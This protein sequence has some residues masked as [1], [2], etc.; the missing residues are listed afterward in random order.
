MT[1]MSGTNTKH[2]YVML[3][4]IFVTFVTGVTS[5]L[6]WILS[7][8]TPSFL[9]HYFATMRFHT[10][11]CVILTSLS[12]VLISREQTIVY[13]RILST[14]FSIAVISIALVRIIEY[15]LGLELSI[16]ANPFLQSTAAEIIASE[17]MAVGTCLIFILLNTSILLL[18]HPEKKEL[19]EGLILLSLGMILLAVF[20]YIFQSDEH[21][22]VTLNFKLAQR[23]I[24]CLALLAFAILLLRPQQGIAKILF[25]DTKHGKSL[26]TILLIVT[27][28]PLILSIIFKIGLAL[29]LYESDFGYGLLLTSCFTI[30]FFLVW[31]NA[32]KLNLEEEKAADYYKKM[33]LSEKLFNEF[34]ENIHDVLWRASA[35]EN[36]ITYISPAF[37][38]IWGRSR[39]SIYENPDIWL[40]SVIPEDRKKVEQFFI[41]LAKDRPTVSVE[42]RIIQPD[43]SVRYIYDRGFQLKNESGDLIGLIGIATDITDYKLATL[44]G[45]IEISALKILETSNTIQDASSK[46]LR[47]VCVA[48]NWDYAEIWLQDTSTS[49]LK[50]LAS[51]H[52]SFNEESFNHGLHEFSQQNKPL[53][54]TLP[55]KTLEA[56]KSI[57]ISDISADGI[58]STIIGDKKLVG[59]LGVPIIHKNIHYG[60][61]TFYSL[62]IM[63]PPSIILDT[64]EKI[65]SKIAD[66]LLQSAIKE[67]IDVINKTDQLTGLLNRDAFENSVDMIV[68]QDP[69]QMGALYLISLDQF[70]SLYGHLEIEAADSLIKDI[71]TR[72]QNNPNITGKTILG[73]PSSNRFA[74]FK[75]HIKNSK[76]I[77][78]FA[79]MLLQIIKACFT[80]LQLSSF[81]TS[82]IGIAAYPQNGKESKAILKNAS[83]ALLR[84]K[85]RGGDRYQ[86]YSASLPHSVSEKMDIETRLRSSLEKNEFFLKYQP[87]LDLRTGEIYGVEALIRM[88]RPTRGIIYPD[89][90]IPIAEETGLIVQIGEWALRETCRQIS[91]NWLPKHLNG[92]KLSVNVS[93]EQFNDPERLITFTNSLLKEY[94]IN[95]QSLE[96]EITESAIMPDPEKTLAAIQTL[97]SQGFDIAIDDFGSG[98]SSLNYLNRIPAKKVKIDK[99]FIVDL[100][101]NQNS[102]MIVRAIIALSHSLGMEVIAEGVERKNQ[103]DFLAQEGCDAIQGY[104]FTPP[105]FL[106]ET[107]KFI[108]NKPHFIIP[109]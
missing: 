38:T 85:E 64:L 47:T 59:F 29:H 21:L 32:K 27:I 69:N 13:L 106:E 46:I 108:N 66:F 80:N 45:N 40:L 74:I 107:K 91:L 100:S 33:Y 9:A 105:R 77:T 88:M 14:F 58:T 54:T 95:P 98:Y 39:Q 76:E 61:I 23:T 96:L 73:Y 62:K 34:S 84:A 3:G 53:N 16:T 78:G 22:A 8:D 25:A 68:S 6:G 57:W 75:Y 31:I 71:A 56:G 92:A 48:M 5:L 93:S 10:S 82:S 30:L 1:K 55:Q 63:E 97:K 89:E 24:L 7:I 41:D 86:L 18:D 94:M 70:E 81:S 12:L 83:V 104:L 79:E 72:I 99:S 102:G 2:N 20:G 28:F 109:K 103:L 44:S 42:Y 90:F 60:V 11:I 36:K 49:S 87:Q 15:A 67:K 17:K 37:E 65:S 19:Q 101:E 4:F 50:Y 35:S 43:G 51:W 52:S 26:R